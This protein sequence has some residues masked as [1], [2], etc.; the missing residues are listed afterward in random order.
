MVSLQGHST[1]RLNYCIFWD[2]TVVKLIN[3]A[4]DKPWYRDIYI[5]TLMHLY[6]I[7]SE[8]YN[9]RKDKYSD[10]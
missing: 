8:N 2:V 9:L 3:S 7:Y 4:S 10:Y 1:H 6:R 5:V